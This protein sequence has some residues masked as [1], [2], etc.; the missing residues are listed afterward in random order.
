MQ[1]RD[2][3]AGGFSVS[4]VI[5]LHDKE[6]FIR[7]TL[8]SV[9][10]QTLAPLEVIVVD[11]GSTDG[12]AAAVADLIGGHV[13]IVAQANA[14]PGPARSRGIDEAVGEWIAFL[15]AD[16][17]WRPNHLATLARMSRAYPKVNFLATTFERA[18]GERAGAAAA[19]TDQRPGA[20]CADFFE[21]DPDRE[22]MC[23]SCVAIR[24][25][26]CRSIGPFGDYW[27]GEDSEYWIRL[28]LREVIAKAEAVTAIYTQQTG[29]L[30]ERVDG[31]VGPGAELQPLFGVL[32]RAIDDPRC[33][34]RRELIAA[35]HA[36]L[37][38]RNVKQALYRAD[39]VAARAFIDEL[40]QRERRP[41]GLLRPLAL[42]PAHVLR[43]G[44]ATRAALK[45]PAIG[46]GTPPPTSA[47]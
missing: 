26:T 7:A 1:P 22:P 28:G 47:N 15:D 46:S 39:P 11:D 21:L 20:Y 44:L 43:M 41:L 37:M 12:S 45:R 38:R 10:D 4:V 2:G 19:H 32:R 27:P 24:R 17:L 18:P 31:E 6:K 23:S 9:L 13:R 16:D 5:P 36:Q 42:L 40:Q 3:D 33:A 35:Y 29:G 25:Q 30:M 8:R 14:G 34:E